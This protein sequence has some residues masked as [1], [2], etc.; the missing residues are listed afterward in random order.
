MNRKQGKFHYILQGTVCGLPKNGGIN[1]CHC[2]HS[3]HT[4]LPV[5]EGMNPYISGRP[6][7]VNVPGGGPLLAK[8]LSTLESVD[9]GSCPLMTTLVDIPSVLFHSLR[10]AKCWGLYSDNVLVIYTWK[11]NKYVL[12]T[13]VPCILNTEV[14]SMRSYCKLM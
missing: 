11:Q 5:P 14:R 3:D 12:Y 9:S 6:A 1:I 2:V 10:R 4:L 8:T 7:N 13:N